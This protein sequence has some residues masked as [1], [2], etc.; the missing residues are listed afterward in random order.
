MF[1][2]TW[3]LDDGMI[4]DQNNNLVCECTNW[5]NRPG[6]VLNAQDN[7]NMF[8]AASAPALL[9]ALEALLL[10]QDRVGAQ[11]LVNLIRAVE[12][13]ADKQMEDK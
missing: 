2:R 7:A 4:Y 10:E 13:R 1:T 6:E 5:M 3:E 9:V 12:S 11:N 8:L